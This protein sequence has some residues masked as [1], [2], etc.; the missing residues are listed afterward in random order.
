MRR[1][2]AR[3]AKRNRKLLLHNKPLAV[4]RYLLLP[5]RAGQIKSQQCLRNEPKINQKKRRRVTKTE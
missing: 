2:P 4:S 5:L 1:K 3:S